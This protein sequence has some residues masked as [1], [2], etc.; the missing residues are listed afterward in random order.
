VSEC[1]CNG[2]GDKEG[3]MDGWMDG[4]MDGVEGSE[5]ER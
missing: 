5:G 1:G 3:G 2:E 4:R